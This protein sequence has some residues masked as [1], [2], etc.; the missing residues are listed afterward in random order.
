M[1]C[2]DEWSGLQ[3]D[4]N[5]R[6][7]ATLGLSFS[8]TSTKIGNY[9][10]RICILTTL[11]WNWLFTKKL[12]VSLLCCR[13]LRL[14]SFRISA[15]LFK[16]FSGQPGRAV[17]RQFQFY[18]KQRQKW[19]EIILNFYFGGFGD[20]WR[21]KNNI[22]TFRIASSA[23]KTAQQFN[24]L[25]TNSRQFQFHTKTILD[26]ESRRKSRMSQ[27]PVAASARPL[28][29]RNSAQ[30]NKTTA[31]SG[32]CQFWLEFRVAQSPNNQSQS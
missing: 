20:F 25:I 31:V 1:N 2:S 23:K 6:W 17:T 13:S 8:F 30:L 28:S 11:F 7:S 16:A 3:Q 12:N 14:L 27:R 21:N 4:T 24:S 18:A 22:R 10:F 32:Q 9:I 15:Q 26:I 5:T 19:N 29:F